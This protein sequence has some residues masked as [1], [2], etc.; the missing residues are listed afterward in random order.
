MSFIKKIQELGYEIPEVPT[1]VA[2]YIPGMKVGNLVMTSGVLP[3]K[4]GKI[5]YINEIG[6]FVNSVETGYKA[7]RLCILNALSIVN[8][9]AGIDNIERIIKVTGYVNSAKNFIEQPKVIN[10]ASEFLVE[11]FGEQGKHIRSAVGVNAL[12]L[13]ASVEIELIVQ[14]RL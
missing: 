8:D 10:G 4:D 3:M 11:V 1:P 9:I 7:A 2:A 12:P 5:L 6:G 13:N 14:V